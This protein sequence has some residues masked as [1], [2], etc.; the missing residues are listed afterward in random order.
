MYAIE[1]YD[2][3][4]NYLSKGVVNQLNIKV[5]EGEIFG[6]LGSNGAGKTTTIRMLTTVIAPSSGHAKVCGFDVKKQPNLVRKNTSV[7]PQGSSLN[8]FL[9]VFDNIRIYLLL[10]GYSGR[11]ARSLTNEAIE[12]FELNEHAYKKS[13]QLSGGLRKRVQI[14]RTLICDSPIAF[15]DEPSTGLDPHSKHL[16]WSFIKNAKQEGKT[17]FLT[18]QYMEE[19]EA[20]ADR[21]C[22]MNRGHAVE[23]GDLSILKSAYGQNKSMIYIG[24]LSKEQEVLFEEYLSHTSELIEYDPSQ[25]VL[26]ITGMSE[27]TKIMA[28]LNQ[29]QI[30]VS[31]FTVKQPSLEEVYFKVMG[32]EV[33]SCSKN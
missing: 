27:I 5:R 22:F 29:C 11:Q 4:K 28:F 19:A 10:K 26:T 25:H 1:T 12:R 31:S 33:A 7:I 32:K 2:L 24:D 16:T 8:L 13:E 20:L 30:K 14:A 6:F 21:V 18:T 23:I 9:N 3:T 17:I 15:L